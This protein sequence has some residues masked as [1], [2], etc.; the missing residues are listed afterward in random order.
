MRYSALTIAMASLAIGLSSLSTASAAGWEPATATA[1]IAGAHQSTFMVQA[2]VTL[3]QSCY[4]ARI[5]STPISLHAPRSFYV[6]EKAP[7]APC[8]TQSAYR[9]TVLSPAFPL[10][11][12]HTIDVL[13]QGPKRWKVPVRTTE[14]GPVPPQ[15]AKG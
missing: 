11:I 14:P 1:V 8:K 10:P 12:P 3:P 6:E 4:A 9:C 5:R 2:W 7:A 13:S 15:C